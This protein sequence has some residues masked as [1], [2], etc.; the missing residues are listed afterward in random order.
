M[1][2]EDRERPRRLDQLVASCGYCSRREARGWLRRAGVTVDGVPE[3]SPDRHVLPSQVRIAGE[4][5]DHPDGLVV[6]LHKVAGTVCTQADGEGETVYAV[7]PER[8][9]RRNPALSAAG[10]LDKDAS[11]L[12]LLTD[13]GDL[14][15]EWTS[16]R[17]AAAKVYHVTLDR[18]VDPSWIPV[19]AGGTLSIGEDGRTCLPAQLTVLGG[20]EAQLELHEG[21]FHQVKRMF[22]V[23][24]ALVIRLHRVRFGPF[25]LGDLGPGQW[26]VVEPPW[27]R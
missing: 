10:R 11:G 14:I 20:H 5:V 2:K 12:L 18:P 13:Q 15:H 3:I 21:R 1:L 17:R 27:P 4:P 25:E 22:A 7:L 19:F 9:R 23:L 16:P 6:M 24:G 8:W 26:R